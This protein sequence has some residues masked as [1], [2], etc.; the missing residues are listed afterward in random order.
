MIVCPVRPAA[1]PEQRGG[2]GGPPRAGL[3]RAGHPRLGFRGLDIRGLGF[4]G[5]GF[6]G[7]GFRGLGFR[8][9]PPAQTAVGPNPD[10]GAVT[11]E[12]AVAIPSLLVVLTILVWIIL[13][14]T[15]QLRAY[16][17]ARAGAR[18]AARGETTRAERGRG[19]GGRAARRGCAWSPARRRGAG[20]GPRR[21][22]SRPEGSRCCRRSRSRRW[23]HA[24]AEDAVGR[25]VRRSG[26]IDGGPP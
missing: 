4:R 14:V 24:A 12:T 25:R 9:G 22:S 5:L 20:G 8:S 23:P 13:V 17:A 11:A 10:H 2:R 18:A 15:A 26:R 3:P 1:R 21:W 6:R 7:L 19:R 16:D